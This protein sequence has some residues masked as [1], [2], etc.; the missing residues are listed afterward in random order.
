VHLDHGA[1]FEICKSCV[2]GGFTSVMIDG[3]SRS[4]EEN[5]RLTK[6]VVDYAHDRG[7]AVEGELAGSRASR[8]R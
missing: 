3:S 6:Q 7:V 1:D 4:F 2:D 8:T 5:I